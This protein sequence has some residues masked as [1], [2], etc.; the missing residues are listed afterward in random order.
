MGK[1]G[2]AKEAAGLVIVVLGSGE[3]ANFTLRPWKRFQSSLGGQAARSY[4]A[5]RGVGVIPV[6]ECQKALPLPGKPHY[7][8]QPFPRDAPGT[9]P[10]ARRLDILDTK[11][12]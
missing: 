8:N 11:I 7:L 6:S 2:R 9:G 5:Y 12:P 4:F 3:R 10:G 1:A